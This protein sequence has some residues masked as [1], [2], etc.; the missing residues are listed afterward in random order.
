MNSPKAELASSD[1][2]QRLRCR[3]AVQTVG[4]DVSSLGEYLFCVRYKIVQGVS[5]PG[6]KETAFPHNQKLFAL[7]IC[8]A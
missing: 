7:V 6:I 5:L 8:N 1:T 3:E 4:G 2:G